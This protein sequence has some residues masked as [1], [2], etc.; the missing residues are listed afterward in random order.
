MQNNSFTLFH[1]T[2]QEQSFINLQYL[3][4]TRMLLTVAILS[5][6]V[7]TFGILGWLPL[8]QTYTTILYMYS[9]VMFVTY[10]LSLRNI[11]HYTLYAHLVI[12]SSLVVLGC[13]VVYLT[14]DSSRLSWFFPLSFAGFI[15]MGKHY[16]SMVIVSIFTLV[17][18][19]FMY[20]ELALSL[21][22]LL[23]F[24]ASLFAFT[25]FMH[26]F[27]SKIEHDTFEFERMVLEEVD[28]RQTQEQILLRKYRMA[29]MG[30]MIDAIAHQWRQPLAQG[31]MILLN[32]QE[33]L[34]NSQYLKEKIT[35]LATLN[36]HMS[37]TIDDF[38][39]LLHE[40][41]HKT[42][43]NL[44]HTVEEVLQLMKSQLHDI[45]LH[46]TN[47]INQDIVGYKNELIQVLV[48]ILSN[49][50]E[51]LNI[52]Q[53]THR[54][55]SLLLEEKDENVYIHIEDNA[56]GIT[57]SVAAKLFDPYITTKKSSGGTGLGLYIAKIIIE[58]T[59]QGKLFVTQGLEGARF[60]LEIK[61][62]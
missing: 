18:I 45:N 21:Y 10:V 7:G 23:T 33:E 54:K 20:F 6:L 13:M 11:N 16:G 9:V 8:G 44:Q 12:F 28:K 31:S 40:S 35:Q 19:L 17:G 24:F 25:I 36:Q 3:L 1:Q 2:I 52:R 56:G 61:R 37:Q 39:T 41:K 58:D 50:I 55:I 14:Y 42:E 51:A 59:M 27:L 57:S 48:I 49:A 46:Y 53:I 62:E 34:D 30:E 5:L 43:F 32:M 22:D 15:L 60:T 38:R 29:N 4:L 47:K 26:Y